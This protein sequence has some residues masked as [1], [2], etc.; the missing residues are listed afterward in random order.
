M[1]IGHARSFLLAWWSARSQGGEMLLRIEDLDQTR[2]RQSWADG[3]LEDLEWLGLDWDGELVMQSEH[4]EH[5]FQAR[6]RLLQAGHAY[7]CVCSRKEVREAANAPHEGHAPTSGEVNY[8]GTCRGRYAS[9]EDA[10]LQ[11]GRKA[12]LRFQVPDEPVRVLDD[13]HGELDF[14]LPVHGGDFVIQRRDGLPAYQLGVVVDDG[15]SRINEV[16]RGDDLLVSA[17]RQQLLY[18]A[19]NLPCPAWIHVP[20]VADSEGERLAKRA[21]STS[22]AELRGEGMLAD[23]IVAWVARSSGMA[24]AAGASASD[25]VGEFEL[26]KIPHL[27]ATWPQ[28]S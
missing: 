18:S 26:A 2:A 14:H 6:D 1:H 7:A 11:S 24:S 15:R 4:L 19:L 3:I 13:F 16:L 27:V 23:Q 28:S 12:A 10:E 17:A 21:G 9:L 25:M 8:P 5:S 22:L 20:L